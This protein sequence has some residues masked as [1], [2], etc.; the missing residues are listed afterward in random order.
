MFK[1]RGS[2][3]FVRPCVGAATILAVVF[4]LLA[5]GIAFARPISAGD[6]N[7]FPI[8]HGAPENA[9]GGDEKPAPPLPTQPPCVLCALTLSSAVL[10]TASAVVVLRPYVLEQHS[11]SDSAAKDHHAPRF[12]QP[13][14]PPPP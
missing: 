14:G 1:L 12:A 2:F 7:T 11:V 6:A 8:C 10:P 3:G 13:R 5:S 9:S 4:H